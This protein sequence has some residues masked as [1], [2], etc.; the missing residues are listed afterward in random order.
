MKRDLTKCNHGRQ[1]HILVNAP[2]S[3]KKNEIDIVLTME[4][5]IVI[6]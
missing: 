2:Y 3:L 6:R 4:E 5:I 1:L